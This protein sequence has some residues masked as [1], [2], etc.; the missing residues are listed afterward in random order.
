MDEILEYHKSHM[1]KNTTRT[2]EPKWREW[3]EWCQAKNF[4]PGGLCLPGEYIDEGKL[5]LFMLERVVNRPPKSGPRL[6]EERKRQ[7]IESAARS[8][9][10]PKR[11]ATG[12]GRAARVEKEKEE[13]SSS[14]SKDELIPGRTK[15]PPFELIL[16]YNSIRGYVSAIIKLWEEQ[17][18]GRLHTAPRPQGMTA[19]ALCTSLERAQFSLSRSEL[20]DRQLNTVRDDY[21][22]SQIPDLTYY[23]W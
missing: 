11:R 5:L 12:R 7:T 2:Y 23:W 4:Q 10:K 3:R 9:P 18:S 13:D 16:K 22:P 20:E 19:R 1:P 6:K 14:S 17:V 15:S 21:L 8:E